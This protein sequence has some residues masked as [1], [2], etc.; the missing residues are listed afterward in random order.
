MSCTSIASASV[1][2]EEPPL[3]REGL[4]TRVAINTTSAQDSKKSSGYLEE[5]L[6]YGIEGPTERERI[7]F[8]HPVVVAAYEWLKR[9]LFGIVI[10]GSILGAFLGVRWFWKNDEIIDDIL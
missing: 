2:L 1:V 9:T 6:L 8:E 10:S 4:F 3:K 5:D 7:D